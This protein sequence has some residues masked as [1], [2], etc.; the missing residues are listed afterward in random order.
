MTVLDAG[1]QLL[2]YGLGGVFLSL[3]TFY[4]LIKLLMAISKRAAK[5]E[6]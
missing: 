4:A 1:W 2:L 5:Q 3:L 6:K